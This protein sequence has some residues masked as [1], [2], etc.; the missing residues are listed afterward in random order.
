MERTPRDVITHVKEL[1]AMGLNVPVP[2]QLTYR[3]RH[4]GLDLSDSILPK[5]N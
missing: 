1:N 4:I 2:A 5:K 3:L